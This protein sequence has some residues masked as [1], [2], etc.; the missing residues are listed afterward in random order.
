MAG[1]E[2]TALTC[3]LNNYIRI[4]AVI[5]DMTLTKDSRMGILLVLHRE[6]NAWNIPVVVT[7]PRGNLQEE[8]AYQLGAADYMNKPYS[9]NILKIWAKQ[10]IELSEFRKRNAIC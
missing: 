1:D 9:Q 6:R 3:L 5:L 7:A 2:D 10:A 8:R 4:A